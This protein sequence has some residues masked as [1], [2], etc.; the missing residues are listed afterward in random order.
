L[1]FPHPH[2]VPTEKKLA[3]ITK[4]AGTGVQSIEVTSFVRA[5]RVPQLQDAAEVCKALPAVPGV[6]YTALYLNKS[7]FL[8]ALEHHRLSTPGSVLNAASE[9][10]L[11]RNNNTTIKEALLLLPEWAALFREHQVPFQRLTISTA[12]GDNE[13]GRIPP[14]KTLGLCTE[15]LQRL[16]DCGATIAEVTFADTTGW[17]NPESVRRLV[18]EFRSAFPELTVALHLHDTRGTGMANVYAGLLCGVDHFDCSVGGMGGCPFSPGAAGNVPTEDVVFLCHELGIET[19]VNLD[20]YIE[21][22]LYAES[23]VG[24]PLP[25]KVKNASQKG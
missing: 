18:S 11:K 21:A 5:D 7:G 4:L 20:A 15:A 17:G 16:S 9:S 10:F 2:F 22:A 12:F 25:G 24:H 3:L 8:R 6:T 14:E 1:S 13:E 19:G 23:L